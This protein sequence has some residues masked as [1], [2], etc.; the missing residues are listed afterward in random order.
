MLSFSFFS[1]FILDKP[2]VKKIK[3]DTL[4]MIA[5][6]MEPCP[7]PCFCGVSSTTGEVK[8]ELKLKT[9]NLYHLK[10]G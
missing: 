7:F 10:E 9:L 4:A 2:S 3:S 6:K 8:G 5:G 1:L